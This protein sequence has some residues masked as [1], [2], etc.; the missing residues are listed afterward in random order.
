M[1]SRPKRRAASA[2]SSTLRITGSYISSECNRLTLDLS[3]AMRSYHLTRAV[4]DAI[5]LSSAR[6]LQTYDFKRAVLVADPVGARLAQQVDEA[7]L[8]VPDCLKGAKVS[9]I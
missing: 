1:P 2:K 9:L 7:T 8:E 6:T 5:E 4:V 3:A